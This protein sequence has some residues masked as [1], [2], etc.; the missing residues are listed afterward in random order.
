LVFLG[1]IQSFILQLV[2][3]KVN[4]LPTIIIPLQEEHFRIQHNWL[5]FV[6]LG[7]YLMRILRNPKHSFIINQGCHSMVSLGIWQN[8]HVGTILQHD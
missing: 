6:L 5:I 4:L 2:Q 3:F 8:L 1:L 7:E